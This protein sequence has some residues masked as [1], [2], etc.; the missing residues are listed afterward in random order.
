MQTK[1]KNTKGPKGHF[2]KVLGLNLGLLVVVVFAAIWALSVW[3]DTYTRHDERFAT[4]NVMGMS[5]DDAVSV[6]EKM[7]YVPEVVDTVEAYADLGTIVE[8]V[9]EAGSPI[10][11]NRKVYLTMIGKTPKPIKMINVI[12]SSSRQALT[13]LKKAGFIIESVKQV[14][15][16]FHDAVVSVTIDNKEAI[17]GQD[18]PYESRLVVYVG[19]THL[20]LEANNDSIENEWF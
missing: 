11:K 8:Q 19:S 17:P 2:L 10:K 12:D 15:S 6:L 14:A 7:G 5:V 9:P 13:D 4:P 20:E 1:E 3:L 18:Y 16:E